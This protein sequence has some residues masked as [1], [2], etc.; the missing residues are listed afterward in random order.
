MKSIAD[1][2]VHIQTSS[3]AQ[4]ATPSWLGEVALVATHLRKQEILTKICER[5]R[6]A[7]RRFGRYDVLDFVAVLFGYA[8]SGE[9]TLEAFYEV[10][11]PFAVPFMALFGRSRLPAASTLSRFLAALPAEPV[12]ALRS[13]F[14]EDL[15]ARHLCAEEQSAGLWDRQGNRWMVFDIDGT[16]E[17]AR[18]R[19]L[20]Q[21]QDRP[22]PQRRLRPLCAPG[23][24]GR[25]RGEVVRSR[26][27]ILQAHTHQL[28]GTFGNPGNG[29]YREELRRVKEVIQAYREARSFCA[30]RLVFRLDGQYGTG[31]VVSD[32][33][34]FSYVTRGKDYKLL[35]RGTIQAR[36]HLPA[37]QH[38]ESAESGICRSLYDCPGQRCSENGSLVRIIVATH[39]APTTK[40][41]KRQ[42]GVRRLGMV[43]EL[44][45]TNLPQNAFTA[46][47]VVSL[48]LH[49]G[50]FETTLED[51][52]IEQ[53]PDRWCSHSVWG[54]E[55]WQ[56]IAQWTWNLRLELGHQL[57][58]EPVRTTE[59]APALPEHLSDASMPPV[60]APPSGYAPPATAT[61]WKAGRFTG[62]D[63]PLQP[64]GTL[65]CPA[66]NALVPHE[67]RRERDGSLRIVYSASIRV[68]RPC[69][70]RDQCQWS[71]SET[72]KPRQVSI[73]L[74]PLSVGSA[75]LL[76]RDWHRRHQRHACL[77]LHH[78][79]LEVQRES[80]LKRTDVSSPPAISRAQRAHYRLSWNER[81]ARNAR[82]DQAERLSLTLFGIPERLTTFLGLAT[83]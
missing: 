3:E 27:V 52:D 54:Q 10:V 74:H 36:L 11:Q 66:G 14:L 38:L 8:I 22:A 53:E 43:Y 55:A 51:E 26:T 45:L 42:V 47:D 75:P 31:A 72:A 41:K 12:E 80:A 56:I 18:Q 44:F 63:F 83:A 77:R 81:L 48:Y 13:L 32:L 79:H 5:V 33:A 64:D 69:S 16:R 49:R 35:D 70:L 15:L 57:A 1:G 30:E 40:K 20:P 71:G 60:C 24:T 37:D 9:R 67:H 34:D 61:S 23:Y 73:L 50:A 7:R 17:A 4:F 78:Q 82:T 46:C 25:K 68:C 6:F 19:A 39:P 21:T 29:R 62:T 28:L 2:L 65:R 76:W 58:P 59:F